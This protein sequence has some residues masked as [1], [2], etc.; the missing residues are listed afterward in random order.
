MLKERGIG[1]IFETQN[2]NTLELND[3]MILTI[4]SAQ[5]QAES[6]NISANVKW[7][8]RQA[9]KEGR[10]PFHYSNLLGYK[11]DGNGEIVIVEEEA[12][13]VR[14]VFEEYLKGMSM[15]QIKDDLIRDKVPLKSGKT[16]WTATIVQGMLKNEKFIGDV[17]MQ[18]TYTENCL[19]KKVRVNNG[20]LPKYYVHNHHEPIIE[21]AVYYAVHEEMAR[22]SSKRRVSDKAKTEQGKYSGKYA[23]TERLYCGKCG[24]RYKRVT[25]YICGVKKVVWRCISR[26]DYGTRYCAESPSIDETKLHAAIV[27]AIH[28]VGGTK[29]EILPQLKNNIDVVLA[30]SSGTDSVYT[31]EAR[32]KELENDILEMV[33]LCFKKDALNDAFDERIKEL[34]KE[35]KGHKQAIERLYKREEKSVLEQHRLD[36]IY[37][38]IDKADTVLEEYDD[39][40]VRKLIEEVKVNSCESVTVYFYGGIEIEER[41]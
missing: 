7:G 27:R 28:K 8:V 15:T 41:L 26:V 1:V 33:K 35:V 9:Y 24:S 17:M 32:V 18:K 3:E 29:D 36:E 38:A 23:L 39:L 21:K 10:V 25:W 19:T 40:L 6:E 22:R 14:R 2:L 4:F 5:A 12:K 37:K 11:R 16:T 34:T 20:E 30:G 13:T 31:H